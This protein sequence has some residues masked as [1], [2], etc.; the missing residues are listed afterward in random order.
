MFDKYRSRESRGLC[1]KG[2]VLVECRVV[3]GISCRREC[4]TAQ[5]GDGPRGRALMRT[6]PVI[7]RSSG[8]PTLWNRGYVF[9][10]DT[11]SLSQ[12]ATHS[13]C[14]IFDVFD[15]SNVLIYLSWHATSPDHPRTQPRATHT[16][17]TSVLLC[18]R[19]L[20]RN[21]PH[22]PPETFF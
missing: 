6:P 17:I 8:T 13:D 18:Q 15:G 2:V 4:N 11:R 16:I 3:Y 21:T 19:H 14:L 5:W 7:S 20:P 9:L 1:R 22:T 12:V 10:A